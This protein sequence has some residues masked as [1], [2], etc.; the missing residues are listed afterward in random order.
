[1]NKGVAGKFAVSVDP[2]CRVLARGP[3]HLSKLSNTNYANSAVIC[4]PQGLGR[5]AAQE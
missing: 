1:M 3:L 2:L 5:R 4:S